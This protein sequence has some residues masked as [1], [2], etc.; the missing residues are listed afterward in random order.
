[1]VGDDY[2]LNRQKL[3]RLHNFYNIIENCTGKYIALLDGDDYWTD[4]LKLQKQADFLEE[5]QEY[6]GCFHKIKASFG[7]SLVEDTAIENRYDKVKDKAKITRMDLL[8]EGNFI[9]SCS[10]VFR[11][12]SFVF[13]DEMINTPV[14]DILFFLNVCSNGYLKRIDDYMAVYRRG[15]GIYSS[16]S[17]VE[18]CKKKMQYHMCILSSLVDLNER[19]LFLKISLE[20]IDQYEKVI[21]WDE[22]SIFSKK[23]DSLKILIFRFIKKHKN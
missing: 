6:A 12:K 3:G 23:I 22:K 17:L 11:N 14:G 21:R 7:D 10:F 5:N 9:H 20:L 15:T 1:K 4:P 13:S 8:R 2:W 19:K 16:L 18:M